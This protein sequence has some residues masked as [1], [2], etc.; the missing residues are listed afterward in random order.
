M[1][2]CASI[3]IIGRPSAGKSTLLNAIC[4]QKVSIT[5]SSPQ[6]TRNSIRGILTTALGQLIFTDTPGYHLSDKLLNKRLQNIAVS[7]LDEADMVVYVIDGFRKCGE[8][9]LAIAALVARV[10]VPV[11]AVLNK[12]D[13]ESGNAGHTRTTV[14]EILPEA[15]WLKTSA[16]TGA[17]VDAL[18][19]KM[20]E[21]APEGDLLYPDDFYTDQSPEFRISEII[22][23]KAVN[24]A[25]QELP[26]AIYV[27]IA[28]MEL[29]ADEE[30]LWIRAFIIVERESQKGLVVGK[31]GEGIKIIRQSAQKEIQRLFPYHIHLDLRVK[32]QPN[33]RTKDHILK[34]I[35]N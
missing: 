17:G 2:K 18:I 15:V 32:A 6:T 29:S 28:D 25:R 34:R 8:E 21:I 30:K 11:I 35:I 24:R 3:A 10:K 27:E 26:H 33:W 9:E 5:A 16:S 20:F 12:S 7:S 23:E 13:M 14:S 19:E 31:G 4:G 22:R 1:T